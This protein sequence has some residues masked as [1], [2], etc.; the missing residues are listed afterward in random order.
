M[1]VRLIHA[2]ES[3]AYCGTK[4]RI[5]AAEAV[6]GYSGI[7]SSARHHL[8]AS[9]Y[10]GGN[11]IVSLIVSNRC[12]CVSAKMCISPESGTGQKVIFAKGSEGW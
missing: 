9:M 2:L 11:T 8:S 7:K 1:F 10:P 3:A 6:A 12:N 5:S 4:A